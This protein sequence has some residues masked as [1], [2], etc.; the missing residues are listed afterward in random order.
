MARSFRKCTS[1]RERA[2][3]PMMLPT[4]S[5]ELEHD[6]RKY[7]VTVKDFRVLQ[8]QRCQA[9]VFDEAANETLSNALRLEAGLLRPDEIHA[10]REKLGLTQKQLAGFLRISES[11]LS[12]WET[13]AQIQQRAMD[14]LLRVYFQS[15]EARLILGNPLV[16]ASCSPASFQHV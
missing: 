3:A 4:Y 11:T 12:R 2:V 6:G 5:A 13:G 10:N 7:T 15:T 8:C 14:A 9:I 1:C 16:A